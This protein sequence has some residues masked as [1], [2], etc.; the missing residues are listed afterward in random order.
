[1]NRSSDVTAECGLIPGVLAHL[2]ARLKIGQFL[3]NLLST[4]GKSLLFLFGQLASDPLNVSCHEIILAWFGNFVGCNGQQGDVVEFLVHG[5]DVSPIYSIAPGGGKFGRTTLSLAGRITDHMFEI[6]LRDSVLLD[7]FDVVVGPKKLKVGHL[8]D[9]SA[10]TL[11]GDYITEKLATATTSC[12]C[13]ARE[14]LWS[15]AVQSPQ[16]TYKS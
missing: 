7:M 3:D 2:V 6:I 1:M 5:N 11:L 9:S 16:P 15:C 14:R 13:S 8:A 10:R 4:F 12:S